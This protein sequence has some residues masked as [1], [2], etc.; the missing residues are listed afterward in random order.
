MLLAA[1]A[2]TVEIVVIKNMKA[3]MLTNVYAI[4]L[5]L[6]LKHTPSRQQAFKCNLSRDCRLC[7][8]TSVQGYLQPYL[9]GFQLVTAVII[10]SKNPKGLTPTLNP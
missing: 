4:A 6:V 10:E 3:M 2:I 1:Y 9:A 8:A 7:Q 5:W